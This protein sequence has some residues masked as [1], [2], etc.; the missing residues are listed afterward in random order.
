MTSNNHDTCACWVREGVQELIRQV[1]REL[2]RIKV[3]IYF[4]A[5]G[6]GLEVTVPP[7]GDAGRPEA[8]FTVVDHEPLPPVTSD[9][10][11]VLRLLASEPGPLIGK[12]VAARLRVPYASPLREL[13]SSLRRSGLIDNRQGYVLTD[14]GRRA[15]NANRSR[16]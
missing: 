8:R 14:S 15:V 5:S 12:A 4:E 9:G 3:R 13:L 1:G 16:P 7:L 11:A 2:G 6:H 10:L